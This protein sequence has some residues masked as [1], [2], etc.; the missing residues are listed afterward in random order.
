MCFIKEAYI[1]VLSVIIATIIASELDW[2]VRT[3]ST[4]IAIFIIIVPRDYGNLLMMNN[5]SHGMS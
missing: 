5:M 3:T 2:M 1:S 4:I